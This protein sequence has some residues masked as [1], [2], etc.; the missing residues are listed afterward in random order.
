MIPDIK[1]IIRSVTLAE[2]RQLA[3]AALEADSSEQVVES[4]MEKTRPI[5]PEFF[6]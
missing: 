6:R 5:L 2:C 3:G 1:K 4:L